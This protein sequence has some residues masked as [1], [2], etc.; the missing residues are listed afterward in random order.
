MK[1]IVVTS[2]TKGQSDNIY[3]KIRHG[4]YTHIIMSPEQLLAPG[5]VELLHDPEFSMSVGSLIIDEAHCVAMWSSFRSE[6]ARIA[7]I[8]PLL[9]AS[10]VL[11][12][13]TATMDAN[14]EKRIIEDCGFGWVRDWVRAVSAI[15]GSVDR[16]VTGIVFFA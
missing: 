6:Y 5:F 8:R 1:P 11:F 3:N 7:S 12:A 4:S 16:P 13:C 2:E 9:P 10:A 14:I 15:H